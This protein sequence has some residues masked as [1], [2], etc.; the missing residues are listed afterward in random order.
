MIFNVY[1]AFNGL[2]NLSFPSNIGINL[3]SFEGPSPPPPM[4]NL[5]NPMAGL[6]SILSENKT[7]FIRLS[8]V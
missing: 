5:A 6:F 1:C 4:F 3:N 2:F 7:L 8:F